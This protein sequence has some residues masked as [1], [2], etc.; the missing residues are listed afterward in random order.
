MLYTTLY[1]KNSYKSRFS[2]MKN[3]V[4]KSYVL[5][6][7]EYTNT[8]T[9]VQNILLNYQTNYSRQSKYQGARNQHMFTQ[10]GNTEDDGGETKEKI[11]S[12]K[13]TRTTSPVMNAKKGHY[14]GNT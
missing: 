14:A 11:K 12:P 1:L 8:V 5:N 6:K 13:G 10:R 9:A 2:D 3:C 4:E 7:S